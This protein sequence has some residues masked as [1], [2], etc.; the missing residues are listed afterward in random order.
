MFKKSTKK[1][2]VADAGG[3][4][5]REEFTTVSRFWGIKIGETDRLFK[6]NKEDSNNLGF[7]PESK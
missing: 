4:I 7:R 5:I 3:M 6:L 2:Q 1:Y